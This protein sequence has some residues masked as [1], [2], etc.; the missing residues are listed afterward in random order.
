[1]SANKSASRLDAALKPVRLGAA[2]VILWLGLNGMGL[3][4]AAQ[5][6]YSQA[7]TFTTFAGIAASGYQDG[8]GSDAQ[9]DFPFGVAVDTNGTIYVADTDNHTI[10]K[11]TSA[12]VVT[13]LAGLAG[14]PAYGAVDGT[15]SAARFYYPNGVAVDLAGNLYVADT[16]DSAIRKVTPAGV[17]TTL[18]GQVGLNLFGTN[19]GPG[20]A[21][22]FYMPAG[23]AV[24]NTGNVFVADSGNETIREVSP[25]DL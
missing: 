2:C 7:Y 12:G 23:V 6:I 22:H 25:S 3:P 19:D 5:S 17:V 20:S 16:Y 11:V 8:V 1:M 24:D 4:A 9:F 13:T 10:R 15:G 14:F 21:A 18:A